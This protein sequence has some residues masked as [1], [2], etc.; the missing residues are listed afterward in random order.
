M[1]LLKY[2]G[3]ASCLATHPVLLAAL[4]RALGVPRPQP[5]RGT[6]SDAAVRTVGHF[7]SVRFENQTAPQP[8]TSYQ[9]ESIWFLLQFHLQFAGLEQSDRE[10][11]DPQSQSKQHQAA[12]PFIL[13]IFLTHYYY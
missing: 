3:P 1:T 7:F 2:L 12:F 8:T 10:A 11:M 5:P 6:H 13:V 4:L 9:Q